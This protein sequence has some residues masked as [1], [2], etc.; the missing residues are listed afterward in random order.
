MI[1]ET[2][3]I[4]FARALGRRPQAGLFNLADAELAYEKKEW[5]GV[6]IDDHDNDVDDA[7]NYNTQILMTGRETMQIKSIV[8]G[9]AIA[10]ITGVGSVS[11][12]EL[13]VADTAGAT[14]APF[15]VIDGIATEQMSIQE[16]ASIRGAVV[17]PSMYPSFFIKLEGQSTSGYSF[18][19]AVTTP[20]LANG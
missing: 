3:R 6:W 9:A 20:K 1:N 8:A 15:A 17:A 10:L 4:R 5:R 14:G 16:L 18:I 12:D 7:G 19:Q 2:L 13:S 11:A